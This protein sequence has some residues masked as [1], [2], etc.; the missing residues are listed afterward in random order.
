MQI[1]VFAA[2]LQDQATKVRRRRDG[3]LLRLR[4]KMAEGCTCRLP[5]SCFRL[6]YGACTGPG[7]RGGSPMR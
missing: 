1:I 3:A 2:I 4:L 6:T 7:S 5:L